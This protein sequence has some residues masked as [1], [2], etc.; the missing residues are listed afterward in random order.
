MEGVVRR[1]RQTWSGNR[2]DRKL[3]RYRAQ[4]LA[5]HQQGD[6]INEPECQPSPERLNQSTLIDRSSSYKSF[7]SQVPLRLLIKVSG[8]RGGLGISI[9][10]GKGSLPYKENDEVPYLP[11]LPLHYPSF[12]QHYVST[13]LVVNGQ[14]MLEVSHHEA[15][16]ALRSAG[17][18][19]KMKILRERPAPPPESRALRELDVSD[20]ESLIISRLGND[21]CQ[22]FMRDRSPLATRIE[23]VICNGKELSD[24]VQEIRP[25]E[26][27]E[28]MLKCGIVQAGKHTMAIP[29]II[30]THPS[31]SDEDVEPLNH[32]ADAGDIDDPDDHIYSDLSSAFYP[33]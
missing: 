25:G 2:Q 21:A 12:H 3:Q 29:R 24:L 9:A 32:D 1:P 23:A 15:V 17:N 18:C 4:R 11:L 16:S 31:T 13:S 20:K 14:D 5:S 10:G 22:D 28:T 6:V 26:E 7:I 30:L 8:Q 27:R 19:V 33:A